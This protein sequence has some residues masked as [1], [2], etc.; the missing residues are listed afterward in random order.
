MFKLGSKVKVDNKW[1]G[2]IV[3]IKGM[4]LYYV[5]DIKDDY[6]Y[7]VNLSQMSDQS[8]KWLGFGDCSTVTAND[9]LDLN[10][11]EGNLVTI[12]LN[13]KQGRLIHVSRF[14]KEFEKYLANSNSLQDDGAILEVKGIQTAD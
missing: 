5:Q 11:Q 1:I 2:T 12:T 10:N 7:M 14:V 3:S 4:D 13:V 9:S 6:V 8:E